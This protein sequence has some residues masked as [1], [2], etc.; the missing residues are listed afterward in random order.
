MGGKRAITVVVLGIYLVGAAALTAQVAEQQHLRDTILQTLLN[1]PELGQYPLAASVSA[2]HTVVLNGTLP[3]KGDKDTAA[4]LVK[5]IAGVKRVQNDITVDAATTPLPAPAAAAPAASAAPPASPAQ[6]TPNDVQTAVQNA[7]AAD[8]SLGNVTATVTDAVVTL[9]G[10]V[11]NRK[12]RDRADR[13]A[14][15]SAP[16]LKLVDKLVIPH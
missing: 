9:T 2:D 8:A 12:D 14:T 16:H 6:P 11:A 15:H 10:T 7:L 3:N 5:S 4:R 13:I 1:D